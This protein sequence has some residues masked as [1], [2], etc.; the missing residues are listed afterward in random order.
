MADNACKITI[1]SDDYWIP[2]D[3]IKD[4]HFLDGYLVNFSETSLTLR[5]RYSDETVYPYISCSAFGTCTKRTA[6]GTQ[7]QSYVN[8]NFSFDGDV[9]KTLNYD[10]WILFILLILLGV[11]LI[12]KR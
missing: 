1:Q 12:W 7:Y 9:F 5:V 4:L 3:R 8:S 6:S 11:R 2:C 10:Y